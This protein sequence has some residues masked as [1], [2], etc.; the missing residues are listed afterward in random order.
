MTRGLATWASRSHSGRCGRA[1]T[2]RCRRALA[3]ASSR[4]SLAIQLLLL[5]ALLLL[6]PAAAGAAPVKGEVA[7]STRDGYARLVFTLTEETDAEVRLNNGILIIAFKQAVEVSVDRIPI[8]AATYVGAARRDPDGTGVRLALNRKVTVNS[9]AAGEK[10]FVDLLPEGW[11]GLAARPAAGSRRRTRPSRARGGEEGAP[12][13]AHRTATC[14]RA[15]ARSRRRAADLHAL[16]LRAARTVRSVDQSRRR[17]DDIHVRSA[18]QV[19]SCRRA[20]HAPADG[21]NDRCASR[22][23]HRVGAFRVHRQGR[24][25]HVPRGQQLRRRRGADRTTWRSGGRAGQIRTLRTC[26]RAE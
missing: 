11:T 17:Q 8:V 21:R 23:R 10:L 7:V 5:A 1:R 9:M 12:A 2:R 3:C 4:C 13:T 14:A 6:Y 22:R 20:G 25:P 26:R 15:G 18:A 16:Y 24:C 19:R